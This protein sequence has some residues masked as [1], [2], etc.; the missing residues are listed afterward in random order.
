MPRVAHL[1][2][3]AAGVLLGV[4]L[5]PAVLGRIAPNAHVALFRGSALAAALASYQADTAAV[6]D[7]RAS[8]VSGVAIDEELNRRALTVRLLRGELERTMDHRALVL[9]AAVGVALVIVAGVEAWLPMAPVPITTPATKPAPAPA[10]TPPPHARLATARYA[11]LALGLALAVARPTLL[12]DLPW[13]LALLLAT[14][15][16]AAP[17][18]PLRPRP[19]G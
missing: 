16:L 2:L 4:A 18:V 1:Y 3:L 10:T 9:L 12:R 7:L 8:G 15:A 17:L 13:L 6:D 19:R 5:G 11:L 14:L